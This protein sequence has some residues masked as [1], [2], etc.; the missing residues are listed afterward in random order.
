MRIHFCVALTP[1][2]EWSGFEMENFEN[3]LENKVKEYLSTTTINKEKKWVY[4]IYL[5]IYLFICLFYNL[6]FT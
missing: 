3:H 5:F 2:T 6:L 1:I 4:T